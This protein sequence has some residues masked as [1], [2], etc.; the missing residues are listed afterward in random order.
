MRKPLEGES[1]G[2]NG[3]VQFTA[4]EAEASRI[5]RLGWLLRA[6]E[7]GV[8]ALK[9][10]Y[11]ATFGWV[12]GRVAVEWSEPLINIAAIISLLL[13]VH[14]HEIFNDGSPA[15]NQ[16]HPKSCRLDPIPSFRC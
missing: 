14:A 5:R 13:R 12:F 16:N 4:L 6:R 2:R 15:T 7:W 3:K 9:T 10:C 1:A 8:N 11:N